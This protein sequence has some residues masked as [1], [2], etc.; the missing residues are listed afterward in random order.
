MPAPFDQ[1]LARLTR[2]TEEQAAALRRRSQEEAARIL[3]EA[4]EAAERD[5]SRRLAERER[6]LRAEAES[7]LERVRQRGRRLLLEARHH[8]VERILARLLLF[9]PDA[10]RDPRYLAGLAPELAE[11][12]RVLDGE[13]VL[14]LAPALADPVRGP[15]T[16]GLEL[17]PDTAVAGFILQSLDGRISIDGTLTARFHRLRAALAIAA[18]GALERP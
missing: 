14:R 4:Q 3:R 18:A 15:A 16:A 8:A 11:A 13:G 5:R 6:E 9:L 1:L 12:R 17:R 7:A 2:D 10:L